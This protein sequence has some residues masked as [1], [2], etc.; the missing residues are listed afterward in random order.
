[1]EI[2]SLN[3]ANHYFNECMALYTKEFPESICEPI[4]V[5][6]NSFDLKHQ[7]FERYH[8]IA[9]YENDTLLGFAS[10]HLEV[11]Y[12]I[13]YIVYLVVSEEARGKNVARALMNEAEII[14]KSLCEQNGTTLNTIMLECEQDAAGNSPLESFYEKFGFYLYDIN[15]H[16]PGLHNDAPV[17]MNLFVKNII[18][19]SSPQL[20]I[21]HM[22]RTKYILCN[23]IDSVVIEDL[24]QQMH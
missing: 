18:N 2:I 24:I 11:M 17:P 8:F 15:Y 21:E 10:F 19:D 20:A 23:K 14:M 5:F 16:Q 1:M 4:D 7:D 3:S 22:Y 9:A 13:G 12:N 6:Y